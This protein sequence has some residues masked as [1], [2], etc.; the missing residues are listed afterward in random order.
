MFKYFSLLMNTKHV[1]RRSMLETFN[2]EDILKCVLLREF[3][4]DAVKSLVENGY[5]VFA[6]ASLLQQN[7]K[8]QRND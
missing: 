5:M 6:I 3:A 4:P 1:Q 2:K 8:M 7:P